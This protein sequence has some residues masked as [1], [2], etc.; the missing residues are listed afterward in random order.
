MRR[1]LLLALTAIISSTAMAQLNY[2][3][4]VDVNQPY[5]YRLESIDGVLYGISTHDYYRSSTSSSTNST[6]VYTLVRYPANR[7]GDTFTLD[8]N[9]RGIA[10]G[11]FRGCKYLKK[12]ILKNDCIRIANDAFD[13]SGIESFVVVG[14][15]TQTSGTNHVVAE[16][17]S[18]GRMY[19]V[20]GQQITE[21]RT[22]EIFIRD[23]KKYIK[24][25]D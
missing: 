16:P 9:V 17:K 20:K 2:S 10:S 6:Y 11:A 7:P 13:D 23:G 1:I 14:A 19:N 25:E 21:P 15:D 3:D 18:D 24:V 12:L 5:Y 4:A 8:V 22:G